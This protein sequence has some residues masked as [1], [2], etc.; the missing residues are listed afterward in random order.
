MS[1]GEAAPGVLAGRV[2]LVP[3]AS[4]GLGSA[5][6]RA[7]AAADASVVLLGRKP[8]SLGRL[9]DAIVRDG[10]DA[11]ALPMD[12]EGASPDDHLAVANAIDSEFGRLDAI[13][14]CAAHFP[15]LTP[16]SHTDPASVAR[17]LHVNLT[18]RIWMLQACLPLLA[19]TLGATVVFVQDDVIRPGQAYWGGYGLAHQAQ[20]ALVPMLQAEQGGNGI[21]VLSLAPGPMRT[22]LR[23]RAFV[24]EDDRLA[25]DPA[26]AATRCVEL[27]AGAPV[28]GEAPAQE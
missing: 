10:G 12:L 20:A 6:A 13:V 15:G 24:E 5:L 23:A 4:G 16:L 7:C 19:R 26:I 2:V 9:V 28:A 25:R 3:G 22:G 17:A 1:R 27:L 14:H 21:R 18:A 8:R 11:T